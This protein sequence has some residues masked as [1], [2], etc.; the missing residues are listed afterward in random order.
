MWFPWAGQ[1]VEIAG[2]RNPLGVPGV[3][4]LAEE[5]LRGLCPATLVRT[6]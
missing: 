6:S 1:P 4:K 2:N 3:M 5:G